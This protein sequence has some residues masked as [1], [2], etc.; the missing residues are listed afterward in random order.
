MTSNACDPGCKLSTTVK[1]VPDPTTGK[2]EECNSSICVINDVVINQVGGTSSKVPAF[3][4]ICP[5]CTAENPCACQISGVSVTGTLDAAGVGAT[6]TQLCNADTTTCYNIGPDGTQTQVTCPGE[7]NFDTNEGQS[8]F[9]V[10]VFVVIFLLVL[11]IGLIYFMTKQRRHAEM[12]E[13]IE[14][15]GI[16]PDQGVGAFGGDNEWVQ[17]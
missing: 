12:S 17:L 5:A 14:N 16:N 3:T 8:N 1:R 10:I 13:L 4:Q 11:I 15:K 6:Y 9:W 2:P 7:S